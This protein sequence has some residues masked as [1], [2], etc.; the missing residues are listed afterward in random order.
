MRT[1][2]WLIVNGLLGAALWA[3]LAQGIQGAKN[4]GLFFAWVAGIAGILTTL[5]DTAMH[6]CAKE[7]AKRPVPK[8]VEWSFDLAITAGLVWFG[9]WWTAGIWLLGACAIAS[10]REKAQKL[11]AAEDD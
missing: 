10:A 4:V 8:Q 1:V 2:K 6:A 3:G 5:S 7:L 9:C 11:K